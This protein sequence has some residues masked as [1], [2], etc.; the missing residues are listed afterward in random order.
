MTTTEIVRL[1]ILCLGYLVVFFSLLPLIRSDY[2]FVRVFDYPRSQKFWINAF[3]LA[4]FL[5]VASYDRTHDL[6]FI[7]VLFLN[8]IYLTS[9]IWD[10]TPLASR[11]MKKDIDN[12][13]DAIK[14]FIANVLQENRNSDLCNKAIKRYDPDIILL[15]ETDDQWRQEV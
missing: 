6:I 1:I 13:N 12:S 3:I 10:Y 5:F 7:G 8:Q 9:L 15:V 2:W 4:A 14:I 11:Q